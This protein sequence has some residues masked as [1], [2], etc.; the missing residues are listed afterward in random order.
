MPENRKV[1]IHLH[2]SEVVSGGT[3]IPSSDVLQHG[4]IAVGYAEGH[5]KLFIKNTND[6]IVGFVSEPQFE[7]FQYVAAMAINNLNDRLRVVSGE[8]NNL[9]NEISEL[10]DK[11]VPTYGVGN[12]GQILT[13]SGGTLVWSN[14]IIIYSGNDSPSSELGN[15]GDIY[16]QTD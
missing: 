6:D 10:D 13:V 7:D 16:L 9:N 12:N 4:E 1:L 3:K 5:E 15:N 14:P 8:T 11:L 2:S